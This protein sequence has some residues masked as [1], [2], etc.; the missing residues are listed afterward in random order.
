MSYNPAYRASLYPTL[1]FG[2]RCLKTLH[3]AFGVSGYVYSMIYSP[4]SWG[5]VCMR[6][7][8]VTEAHSANNICAA[9]HSVHLID[10]DHPDFPPLSIATNKSLPTT[11]TP[12]L[13]SATRCQAQ[14]RLPPPHNKQYNPRIRTLV[15]TLYL[16]V[17]PI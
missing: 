4:E 9:K 14:W 15:C 5:L 11:P 10:L 8:S 12:R 7:S 16:A 6:R 3:P 13:V 2:E 17:F 1:T